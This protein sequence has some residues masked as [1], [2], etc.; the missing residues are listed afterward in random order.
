MPAQSK[1]TSPASPHLG[2]APARRVRLARTAFSGTCCRAWRACPVWCDLPS[3]VLRH[4]PE[5]GAEVAPL[6]EAGAIAD[7]RQYGTRDDWTDTWDSHQ[8]LTTVILLR[9]RL[10]FSRH[11][12]NTSSSRRQSCAK[13]AM[14]LTIRGESTSVFELRIH[15]RTSTEELRA[16]GAWSF[17][18]LA[19]G[20]S[21][22][23][24]Q[25]SGPESASRGTRPGRDHPGMVGDIISE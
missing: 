14:R 19:S 16:L 11:D 8:P 22:W 6:L 24:S 15:Q 2:A 25:R 9:Q 23:T 20:P 4:E 7:R 12:G 21:L 10:D 13:S 1:A 18:L 3:T 5:P 17:S